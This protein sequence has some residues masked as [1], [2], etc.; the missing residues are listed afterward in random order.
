M[1]P[2]KANSKS[3]GQIIRKGKAGALGHVLKLL[4]IV[5]TSSP[6]KA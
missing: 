6:G 4:F 2:G 1:G 3:A 5:G